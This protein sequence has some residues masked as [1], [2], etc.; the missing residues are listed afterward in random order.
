MIILATENELRNKVVDIAIKDL[1][2][3]QY[4]SK[5]KAIIKDFCSI[6]GMGNWMDTSQPWCAA[7]VSV[8]GYRAGLGKIYY[9]SASCNTMISMYK[10][11]GRWKK[12]R[13]YKPK[14][15]DV[16]MFDWDSDGV[17]DHVGLVVHAGQ[18]TYKTI[19]G[20]RHDKVDY[21]TVEIG[22]KYVYGVCLP[23][24]SKVATKETSSSKK[25]EK[26]D[27]AKSLQIALNVSY[28]L[29]LAVDG[30][31]QAKTKQAINYHYLWYRSANV[32]KNAH[33]SWLQSALKELGYSLSV[34][35]KFGPQTYSVLKQ[36]QADKK[37]D[38]DGYAGVQTHITILKALGAY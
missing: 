26:V 25:T 35:G 4:S 1:G 13:W 34:D 36:F 20:N 7:T 21:R 18:S 3:E 24:F 19:E 22:S 33:V 10:A 15:G 16:V 27:W 17:A 2:A 6:P 14:K 8:W 12:D 23:D 38:A 5:H 30:K 32:F 31:V 37:I 28:D 29:N 9:P 11:A